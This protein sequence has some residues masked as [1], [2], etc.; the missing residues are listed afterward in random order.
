MSSRG[1]PGVGVQEELGV[2][3]VIFAVIKKKN[4]VR[5]ATN[6]G[7]GGLLLICI[8]RVVNLRRNQHC[9]PGVLSRHCEI[10]IQSPY[11]RGSDSEPF[12]TA[13]L[14]WHWGVYNISTRDVRTFIQPFLLLNKSDPRIW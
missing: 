3:V 2:E 8:P 4:P 6:K 5:T 11:S 1:G 9:T 14:S 10:L 13:H 7:I 12:S